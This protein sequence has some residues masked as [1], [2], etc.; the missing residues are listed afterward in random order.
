MF[1]YRSYPIYAVYSYN[2]QAEASDQA[3][4]ARVRKDPMSDWWAD[5]YKYIVQIEED[6]D[7]RYRQQ[8]I[9]F[10]SAVWTQLDIIN[11]TKVGQTLLNM[12]NPREKFWIVPDPDLNYNAMTN[13]ATAKGRGGIR[14][15]IN[16]AQWIGTFDDTL[17]HELVHALRL[18]HDR[19]RRKYLAHKGFPDSEEFI[20]TQIANIYRSERGKKQ[21]YGEYRDGTPQSFK[22]TVYQMFVENPEL[23]M[24]LKHD[25]DV[26]ELVKK[27]ALFKGIDFNPY[28][29]YPVL[30][31]MFMS[32][33]PS[34]GGKLDPL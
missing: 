33:N 15:R 29:D 2:K 11:N 19:F 26:E 31:R 7:P 10:E 25:L 9:T 17:V 3:Y 28:K 13:R 5:T 24:A 22:G 30:H 21:L 34:L 6:S 8:K 27:I 16:P 23:I 20:A 18:S 32:N 1:K 4:W 14:I 12:L